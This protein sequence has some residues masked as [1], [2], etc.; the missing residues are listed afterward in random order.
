MEQLHL[1][2]SQL[3]SLFCCLILFQFTSQISLA[4]K[5][6]DV[7]LGKLYESINAINLDQKDHLRYQKFAAFDFASFLPIE[8]K[9]D[10][11]NYYE[12]GYGA[13]NEIRELIHYDSGWYV[14]KFVVRNFSDHRIM[15]MQYKDVAFAYTPLVFFLSKEVKFVVTLAPLVGKDRYQFGM[16]SDKP[17]SIRLENISCVMLLDDQLFPTKYFLSHNG[18]F[19]LKCDLSY[20]GKSHRLKSQRA[21]ILFSPEERKECKV[22]SS[23]CVSSLPQ[24]FNVPDVAI[25]TSPLYYKDNYPLWIYCGASWFK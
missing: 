25:T 24:R 16:L 14:T 4:Q 3:T 10:S 5:K 6:C 23:V 9:I 15:F 20:L 11:A 22:D 18:F 21:Y 19:R 17:Y 8:G 1:N 12:V 7:T 2:R 13:A